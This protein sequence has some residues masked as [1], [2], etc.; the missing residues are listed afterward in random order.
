[1]LSSRPWPGHLWRDKWTALSG[2]L[3]VS[4][5][6]MEMVALSSFLIMVNGEKVEWSNGQVVQ[7][8]CWSC[9]Q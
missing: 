6:T 7:R 9:R 1:M 4:E 3:A 8:S 2:P 5:K